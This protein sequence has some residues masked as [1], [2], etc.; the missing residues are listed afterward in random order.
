MQVHMMLL[1]CAIVLLFIFSLGTSG[2]PGFDNNSRC[3]TSPAVVGATG[4]MTF[5]F[6]QDL[7]MSSDIFH[8]YIIRT[9]DTAN[10]L[11][12]DRR[13]GAG[14]TCDIINSA[15][16]HTTI[17]NYSLKL[18]AANVTPELA[19][20]YT[21]WI[22]ADGSKEPPVECNFVVQ[23]K[24]KGLPHQASSDTLSIVVPVVAVFVVVAVFITGILILKRKNK[25]PCL[26][27]Q[28]RSTTDAP[29]ALEENKR[30]EE[31]VPL[32]EPP[33]DV[34]GKL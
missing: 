31:Q 20:N 34:R 11:Q 16:E 22:V 8:A 29:Q 23:N 27:L 4:S 18:T 10:V 12:C 32:L 30:S 13:K 24:T 6:R 5:L 7:N 26:S 28:T 15:F 33:E 1:Y 2:A 14:I 3:I 17:E 21:L 25:L 9:G 19:G